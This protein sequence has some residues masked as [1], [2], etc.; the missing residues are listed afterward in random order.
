MSFT[1]NP[2]TPI[3]PEIHYALEPSLKR[4]EFIDCLIRSTLAERRPI[5]EPDTIEAMLR[6]ANLICTARLHTGLLVGVARSITDYA[7]CTYLSDLAVDKSYQGLGI[8]TELMQKTHQ[9]AGLHTMLILLSAP[10]AMTYYGH[11]GPK[12]GLQQ[13][14]SAW[15]IPRNQ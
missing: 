6:N 13:H 15:Y 10:N 3:A 4:D 14:P 8:G 9:G 11:V 2:S 12:I 7:F 5:G 1:N